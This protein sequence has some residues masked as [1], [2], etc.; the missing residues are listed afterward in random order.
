M[1]DMRSK[2]IRDVWA[3]ESETRQMGAAL[4]LSMM[5]RKETKGW[6]RHDGSRPSLVDAPIAVGL[7]CAWHSRPVNMKQSLKE[8]Y[9]TAR[10][11]LRWHLDGLKS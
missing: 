5:R 4:K 3:A 6:V 9:T 8:A 2:K 10:R 1:M 7:L 11:G